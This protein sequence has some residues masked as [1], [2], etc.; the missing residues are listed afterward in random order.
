MLVIAFVM[1]III[2]GGGFGGLASAGL[3]ATLGHDVVVLE[4]NEQLGG[5][6]SVFEQ[7]GFVFDMGPSWYLM[8][9][10]FENFFSLM[11]TSA[12]KELSL[13]RLE[14]G[15]RVWFKD[16]GLSAVSIYGD[17]E[18]DRATLETLEPGAGEALDAY[19]ARARVQYETAV[20]HV[21][22]GNYDSVFDFFSF[23]LLRRGLKM[24]I[25]ST[26][27]QYV[28]RFFRSSVIQKLVQYPLVFLGSSPYNTPALYSLM[29]H[30]DFTQGVF[31]PMG[32]ITQ[33]T[34]ALVRLAEQAGATLR[35]HA[36]VSEI[37]VEGGKARG[38]VLAS[39]ERLEADVVIS[40]A[41]PA[42][43]EQ[44]LL[45]MEARDHSDAYWASRTLAPSAFILYLGISKRLPELSHHNLIFA[46]DWKKGFA[47]IFDHPQ[48]PSDPSFY[49][50]A[51][52]RTD[53]SVAPEGCENLFV[54]VP[55]APGL[56]STQEQRE[57]F[58]DR[59]LE[60]I[61]RECGVTDL[62]SSIRVQR[63]FTVEDFAE[64]YNAPG[65]TALGLAHTLS[66]TAL[67]RPRNQSVRV[68][69]LYYVGANVNPGIG[70]PVCLISAELV[71]KR[72][73]GD[74]SRTPLV[75][76]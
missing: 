50:C 58:A 44:R 47:E 6:A 51:P 18:R 21:L 29:S 26:M 15:Y 74:R 65:G 54:L 34:R 27:D 52:S 30:L 28:R 67:L 13:T 45:P 68:P 56:T 1:R 42:F 11:G 33:I 7:D 36:D 46:E 48:W 75:K 73:Q 5:R 22:Y 60:T 2:I 38:V 32:G 9:D 41:D 37:L 70:M 35:T 69:N 64:R 62:R 40:N 61:E 59:I 49:V 66:Q 76:L 20:Q 25:F 19:L 53:A 12:E 16:A 43:T 23:S 24:A 31:Y 3:L 14:P 63:M 72:L 17:R 71:V 39:G 55:I 8:P 10:V 57:A 4:K